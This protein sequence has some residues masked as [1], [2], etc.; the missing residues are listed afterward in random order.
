MKLLCAILIGIAFCAAADGKQGTRLRGYA[1]RPG[2]C[3]G[4]L[5]PGS[6]TND[7]DFAGSIELLKEQ[8]YRVKLAPSATAMYEHFAGTDRKRAADINAF[9]KD[10]DVKAILCVRGGYGSARILDR[11][12]Y[13]MIAKRPKPLI[14][15]SDVTALHVAL[16]EKAGISTIHGPMLVSFTRPN[17]DSDYTREQFFMGLRQADPLGEIPMPMATSPEERPLRLETV[18]PG[19]AEGIIVG[20]NLT[21]LTSLVGTPWELNGKGALLL[22]EDVGE[23]PYRIDRMLNQLWQS[24]L[25]SR[26]SGILLGDFVGCESDDTNPIE[27]FTLEQVLKHYARLSRKPVI[28][29]VPSGHGRY[30]L[31]IPLGVHAVMRGR[32]DGTA[33][34]ILDEAALSK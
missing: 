2:D 6:Y 34:L 14:G 17:F 22:L 9:F 11:L 8:G 33:S 29:G 30:N 28:R 7:K 21:V 26:V 5:A 3:I 27:D 24:G 18:I 31:F 10:D 20:G 19:T 1:L 23:R 16:G 32:E 4:I 15:F 25:L 13:K 12:D